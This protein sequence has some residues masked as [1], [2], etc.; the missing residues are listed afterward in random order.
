MGKVALIIIY[1]H[2]YNKN[3]DVLEQ[4]YK[5]RFSNIYHLVPFYRGEKTNVIPIYESSL[6]FQ[7]YL[8]QGFNKYFKEDFIHYFFVADDLILNPAINE[9]NYSEHLKLSS[10]TCFIPDFITLH[11]LSDW[12]AIVGDAYNWNI[13]SPGVEAQNQLPDYEE[14]IE[15]FKQFGFT[16][17]PLQFNQIWK[18]PSTFKDWV[19]PIASRHFFSHFFFTLRFVSSMLKHKTFPVSFPIIGSYS[20]IF[21]ISSDTIKQF[22]HYCGVF[23]ATR[24][25]VEVALPTSLVLSAKEIVTEKDLKLKGKALWTFEDYQLLDKFEN[26]LN[27]LINEF[28]KDYLY[29]HP[30]KLSKWNTEL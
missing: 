12:W 30:I 1:N 22:C 23:A 15:K 21:V 10:N 6:Y 26:S 9:H 25:F 28:P 5:D 18:T 8:S 19:R 7:G 2:Q 13:K 16:I 3:I 4:M 17:K 20:D 11:E 14:A 24:L 27:Q 29:I